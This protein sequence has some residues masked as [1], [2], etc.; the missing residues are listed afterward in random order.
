MTATNSTRINRR[1]A[2]LGGAAAA[3]AALAMTRGEQH[4]HADHDSPLIGAW[5]VEWDEDGARQRRLVSIF[6]GGI[7][8]QFDTPYSATDDENSDP[9]HY[10]TATVGQW[11]RTGYDEYRYTML[12]LEYTANGVAEHMERVSGTIR[13]D[14]VGDRWQGSRRFET[15]T[16]A[17]VAIET[18]EDSGV[19]ASRIG[20]V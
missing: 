10:E 12:G 11:V 6:P 20:V 15:L 9:P 8:Q 13:Y 7:I 2:M 16:F 14:A 1:R 3:G 18:E 19:T 4:A 5:L 17:G